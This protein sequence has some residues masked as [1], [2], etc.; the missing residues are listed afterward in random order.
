[1]EVTLNDF[2]M[3]RCV[4]QKKCIRKEKTFDFPL[5]NSCIR[6]GRAVC[7]FII[8]IDEKMENMKTSVPT[9]YPG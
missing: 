5:K 2:D 9:K 3:R 8:F 7:S 1:M 4:K 6:L